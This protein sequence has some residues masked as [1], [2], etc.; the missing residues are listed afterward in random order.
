[1]KWVV[2]RCGLLRDIDMPTQL[3]TDEVVHSV[4]IATAK[5]LTSCDMWQFGRLHDCRLFAATPD[6]RQMLSEEKNKTEVSNIWTRWINGSIFDHYSFA[7][8][9]KLEAMTWRNKCFYCSCSCRCVVLIQIT[10]IQ[11]GLNTYVPP[12]EW[13]AQLLVFLT[14]CFDYIPYY[15][16][17]LSESVHTVREL[18]F[19]NNLWKSVISII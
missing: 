18:D 8:C 11:R 13:N 14:G 2:G 19:Q 12:Q 16:G 4:L 9:N 6:F 15:A 7:R 1:M 10:C 17:L 5:H 3:K